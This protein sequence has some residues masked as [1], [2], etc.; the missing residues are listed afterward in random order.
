MKADYQGM[1]AYR[2]LVAGWAGR[3]G[4]I[5][6]VYSRKIQQKCCL[7]VGHEREELKMT[8]R[9]WV[10]EKSTLYEDKKILGVREA[11]V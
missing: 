7:N 4:K 10:L 2:A 9:F 3:S 8:L 5:L 6:H 1:M 11:Q